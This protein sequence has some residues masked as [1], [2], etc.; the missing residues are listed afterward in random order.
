VASRFG[1]DGDGGTLGNVAMVL[2]RPFAISPEKGARTSIYLASSPDV[3]DLS[4]HYFYKCALSTPSA[5]ARDDVAAT[6]LW[7][8]SESLLA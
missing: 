7:Q 2:G 6:R 4:G 5:A 3:A 8:V 1:R